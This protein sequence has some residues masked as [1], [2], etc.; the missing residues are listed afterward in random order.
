MAPINSLET[1]RQ[2]FE[3]AFPSPMLVTRNTDDVQ[4]HAFIGLAYIHNFD[5]MN[6]RDFGHL[7]N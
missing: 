7:Y 2:A 5:G 4:I 3:N 6:K 1:A